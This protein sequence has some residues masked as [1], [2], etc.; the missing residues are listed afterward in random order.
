MTDSRNAI[1]VGGGHNGLICATYLAKAGYQ[2]VLLE[3]RDQLGGAADTR[4]FADGFR[5]SGCAHYLYQMPRNLIK[6]LQL[7]S[8]GLRFSAR[9]LKTTALSPGGDHLSYGPAGVEGLPDEAAAWQEFSRVTA[10]FANLLSRY[11][12]RS[13]PK[14]KNN[15]LKDRMTLARL[16][17]DIRMLGKTDMR[18]FLRVIAINIYDLLNEHFD[19]ERLKGAL[20]LDAVLGTHLGP[21]SP[22]TVLTYLH[23]L[24]SSSGSYAGELMQPEGG[25]GT[26]IETLRLAAIQAGVQIRT[27]ARVQQILVESGQATGVRLQ[28]GEIIRSLTVISNA[29][30]KT[31]VFSLVGARHFEAGFVRKMSHLR[32]KGNAAKLHLALS[33]TPEFSGI[34]ADKLSGRLVISPSMDYAER[35]FNPAKYGDYSPEPVMEISVP[36]LTDSSLAPAGSHVLSAIVQ[37]APYNRV[38]GWNEAAHQALYETALRT[39]ER[40]A[41]GLSGQVV[42]AELLTPTDIE[43]LY[44]IHGG[45]WHHAE[46]TLDQFLFTRPVAGASQYALPVDGVHIC[47]AGAHPGGGVSGLP[48]R[49]AARAI[50]AAGKKS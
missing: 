26:V 17:L 41:P 11:M 42:A 20:S 38:D 4:E 39:L 6:E 37:Y 8:H 36:S 24:S 43:Q 5:A 22:N 35:A 27:G 50:I 15:S 30:P 28:D 48:G 31:T 12:D 33:G 21:R 19:D 9:D 3:G 25:M 14:L 46:L 2:V 45:H 47:G 23:R 32:A 1:V 13:P 10:R 34:A 18:E 40:Y 44:G 29:D 7:E 16:G 49:N